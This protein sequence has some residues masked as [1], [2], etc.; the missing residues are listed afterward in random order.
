M[1]NGLKNGTRTKHFIALELKCSQ[2]IHPGG[3][4]L[5][6]M[7]KSDF[8]LKKYIIVGECCSNVNGFYYIVTYVLDLSIFCYLDYIEDREIS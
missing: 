8:M 5:F 1:K 2:F 4:S 6:K 7:E 3:K